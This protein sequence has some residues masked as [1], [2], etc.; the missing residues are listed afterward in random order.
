MTLS[1]AKQPA[2][3]VIATSIVMTVKPDGVFLVY[4]LH[5]YAFDQVIFCHGTR[6]RITHLVYRCLESD[7]ALV[8]QYNSKHHIDVYMTTW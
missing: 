6:K 3:V 2:A 7:W 1:M 4:G 8:T 5:A